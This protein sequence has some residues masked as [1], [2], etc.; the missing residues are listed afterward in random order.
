MLKPNAFIFK[1]DKMEEDVWGITQ[2][3]PYTHLF[4]D[5]SNFQMAEEQ[6][7]LWHWH[8]EIEIFYVLK[9]RI[10][11][12]TKGKSYS[13]RENE[14]GF[15]NTNVLHR[16][17]VNQKFRD[18]IQIVQLFSPRLL[19]GPMHSVFDDK[20]VTPITKCNELDILKFSPE[21]KVQKEILDYQQKTFFIAEGNDFDKEFE[22]RHQLSKIWC[23]L[24]DFMKTPVLEEMDYSNN[25]GD[26][27][28]KMLLF[29]HHNYEKKTTLED[30]AMSASISIRECCRCFQK[31]LKMTPFEYLI[32][33]RILA[34][35]QKLVYTDDSISSIGY[36]CGFFSNSYFAKVFK[37]RMNMTPNEYRSQNVVKVH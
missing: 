16:A 10:D 15:V 3:F 11:Y 14:G 34:S 29:I 5:F 18:T 13:F 32:N 35:C 28:K 26:R 25:D 31:S 2:E 20:F 12:S 19:A 30:I 33:H 22:I 24:F 36:S 1:N 7:S 23:L 37:E 4:V 6:E 9:G 8:R 21:E 17:M 27:I